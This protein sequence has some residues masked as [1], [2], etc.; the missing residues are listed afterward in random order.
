MKNTYKLIS[1]FFL[2]TVSLF[3]CKDE[4]LEPEPLS[5][6][7]PGNAYISEDGF[8]AI[9][10]KMRKDIR[11]EVSG[12]D[13]GYHFISMEHTLSDL[14]ISIFPSDLRIITPSN[15]PTWPYLKMYNDVYGFIKNS[16]VLI[17]NIDNIDWSDQALHDKILAEALW[18]R[19]YWYYRLVHTYGDIPWVGQEI[20]GAKLDFQTYSREAILNKI[21]S[22]LEWAAE[23][24]PETAERLGDMTQGAAN[25]LLAKVY[26]ANTNFDGAIEAANKV[27]NG[28]YELMTERFGIDADDPV[29]NVQWDLHRWQNRNIAQNKE[30]IYAT[31][32]RPDGPPD[33]RSG[34]VYSNRRYTPSYWKVLESTGQRA[35]NWST[36][37]SDTLGIGNADVRTNAYWHYTIWKDEGYTWETTPDLRRSDINWIEMNEITVNAPGSPQLGEPLSKEFYG[38]LTDTFDTW[39][40]WPQYKTFVLTPNT[41]LPIGGEADW[42]IFRLAETHLLRAEAYFWKGEMGLAAEDINMVRARSNA[43]LITSEEVTIDYIF[44]ERAR[45]LYM[46]EPRHNEMVRVSYI[47]AHENINGYNLNTFSEKNW[48]FDRVMRVNNHYQEPN[49]PIWRGAI[50]YIS[51]HNVLLPI[52]QSVIEANTQAIINQNE[53]YDGAQNNVEPIQTIE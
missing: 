42:Y 28:P 21:Q 39:Y 48:F 40:P 20:E 19:A 7:S 23:H 25:H 14:A 10:V 17:D 2:I 43:P 5:F 26:L 37:G 30:T 11:R 45:E 24:L 27:I 44:D 51:P 33:A 8:E 16:N 49:P 46:E 15:G 38:S 32:D 31:I 1:I 6:F 4:W 35:H 52:P 9:L 18:H 41:R 34:G 3:S 12:G 29:R 50:A 36:P 47:M 22:D 13:G 53:G